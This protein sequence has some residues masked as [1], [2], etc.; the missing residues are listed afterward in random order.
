LR[1]DYAGGAIGAAIC[2]YLAGFVSPAAPVAW[3][4]GATAA[5]FL[6]YFG[7]TVCRQLTQIELD[8]T[9]IRAR[10]PL[11]VAI[12]W[13]DLRSLRLDYYSTRSDP[14]GRTM[15]GGWMQL[16]VCGARGAIRIGS[17]IEGF[18]EIAR[19]AAREAAQRNVALD[20]ATLANL[21]A[22]QD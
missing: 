8:Q 18:A 16:K 11:G 19:L 2:I 4:A 3:V 13:A 5:L 10:G 22:L 14:E 6:V 12:G 15:G 9:G 20:A 17:E 7:R 21:K 1:R